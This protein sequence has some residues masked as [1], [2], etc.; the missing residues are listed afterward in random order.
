[1]STSSLLLNLLVEG[2][3]QGCIYA[4]MAVGFSLLWWVSGIVHLAHGGVTLAGGLMVF[5]AL[6]ALGAPFALSL[7]VGGASAIG[8]GLLINSAI[9]S[10]LL[11]RQTD[12]MGLLT[13][14]LGALIVIEYVLT[15]T[16]GPDGITLDPSSWRRPV[17]PAHL[18]AFD[19]F[20]VLIL[21]S[22]AAIFIALHLLMARTEVGRRLRGI[23][24]NPELA[25]IIG[26]QTSRATQQV[27][28]LAAVLSLPASVFLL[29]STGLAPNEAL[30]LV[31]VSAVIAIIGGRGSLLGALVA[32]VVTGVAESMATWQLSTGWRQLVTFTLLYFVL[33]LRP[34]GIFAKH[35]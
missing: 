2:L 14:S 7:M 35:T 6:D 3:V 8:L 20:S 34:Q 19:R 24:S 11:A 30:H 33:L 9:Y 27:T 10:P 26:L 1:V 17:L 21:S 13:A 29:F 31:L 28:A 15:I 18:P 4:L 5:L 22:T 16:F 32:G 23:A 12:E 25:K